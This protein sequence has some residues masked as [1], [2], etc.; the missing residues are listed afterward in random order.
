MHSSFQ[1]STFLENHLFT[2][3]STVMEL[4]GRLTANA[5]VNEIKDGRKV[6]NFS[7]AINDGYKPKGTEVFKKITTFVNC[8]YCLNTSLAEFLTKGTLVEIYGRISANAWTNMEGKA[9]ASLNFHVSSI[10]LHSGPKSENGEENKDFKTVSVSDIT[11][12]LE[13]LPF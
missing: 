7:V 5:T 13:D 2:L 4:F 3:K 1:S 8:S 12:P 6:I 11:A 10:K 9:K